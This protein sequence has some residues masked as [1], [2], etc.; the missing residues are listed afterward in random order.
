MILETAKKCGG[1]SGFG[2]TGQK[3]IS[4]HEGEKITQFYH[5]CV[6]WFPK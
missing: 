3:I 6:E 4:V 2:A 1:A 5:N